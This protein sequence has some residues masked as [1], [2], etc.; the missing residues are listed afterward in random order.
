M[1]ERSLYCSNRSSIPVGNQ[2]TRRRAFQ[3]LRY[4]L[5]AQKSLNREKVHFDYTF[6]VDRA[7]L[8]GIL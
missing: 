5:C 4:I 6:S 7:R 8:L 2:F 1:L 3:T